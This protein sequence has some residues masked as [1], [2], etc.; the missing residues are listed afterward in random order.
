[1]DAGDYRLAPPAV[2][3]QR[4]GEE[5]GGEGEEDAGCFLTV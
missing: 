3:G 1:M 4:W 2:L 5:G